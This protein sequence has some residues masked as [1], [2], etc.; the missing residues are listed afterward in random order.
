MT[1]APTKP[2]T[3]G[4][5]ID[6][7]LAIRAAGETAATK[8]AAKA[9]ERYVA[10]WDAEMATVPEHLLPAVRSAIAASAGSV[11]E[12]AADAHEEDG[13]EED[14]FGREEA[15]ARSAAPI[16]EGGLTVPAA[17]LPAGAL[18]I[19]PDRA[20]RLERLGRGR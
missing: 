3:L 20:Q 13:T 6:R 16:P 5:H 8:A 9:R 19:D 10:R 4:A 18:P 12:Q 2:R 7:L 15:D 17:G 1:T 14:D 11:E